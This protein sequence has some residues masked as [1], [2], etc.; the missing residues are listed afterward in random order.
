MRI[1]KGTLRAATV[2]VALLIFAPSAVAQNSG[3]DEYSG[4]V[5]TADRNGPAKEGGGADRA[6]GS[7]AS[8]SGDTSAAGRGALPAAGSP[9][10]EALRERLTRSGALDAPG[11]SNLLE[12]FRGL[13]GDSSVNGSGVTD[14]QARPAASATGASQSDGDRT[15][16]L[17]ILL[18]LS[19]IVVTGLGVLFKRRRDGLAFRH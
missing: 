10:F 16:L 9:E 18:A 11:F 4:F 14:A 13:D 19:T 1:D 17:L 6:G 8:G 15:G 5:P 12:S 3:L 2:A 7:G